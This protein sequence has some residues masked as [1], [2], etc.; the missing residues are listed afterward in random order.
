MTKIYT[1]L[2]MVTL[3]IGTSAWVSAQTTKFQRIIGGSDDDRSYSM[4]QTRDGGYI[5]TGY[6]KSFG[7]GGK[8]IYLTKTNGLGKVIWSKTYGTSADEAGWKVKQTYDS[9]YLVVGTSTAR[10]GDGVLFK[11]DGNGTMVWGKIFDSDSTDEIYNVLESRVNNAIYITG[12]TKTDSFGR[13]AFLSKYSSAGNIIWHR[14][15]GGPANEEGFSLVEEINGNI[16][17]VGLVVDDSVTVGGNS[18]SPGDEDFFIARF[19]PNG[20]KKWMK[21][22]GTSSKDQVWDI[23][24]LK[25]EYIM[26]GWTVQGSGNSEIMVATIDTNGTA[27]NANAYTYNGGGSSKAFTLVI[28]PDETISLTGQVATPSNKNDGFYLNITKTGFINN[29][30]FIGGNGDD[31]HWPSEVTRTAD[32]GFT[33]F[34]T[35]NSFK[36]SSHDL[37]MIRMDSKGV[38]DCNQSSPSATS[39]GFNLQSGNFGKV[40]LGAIF[41]TLSLT[42]KTITTTKDSVLCCKLQ[43]QVAA[44]SLRICKGDAIRIGKT[45]ISG[46]VYKWTQLAGGSFTSTESSPQVSPTGSATYR[47]VVSS[48]DGKCLKDSA[49]ITVSVRVELKNKNIVRDTFF[50]SGD[51]I[52]IKAANGLISYNWK[53]KKNTFTGQTIQLTKPDTLIITV[54]DTTTCKYMDTI[55]VE[56]KKLPI[57]SLGN[58]TTICDNTKI[59]LRGP[60]NMKSYLWNSGK[61]TTQNYLTSEE[62]THTLSVVDNFGCKHTDSKQLFNNPAS[63]FS[64]GPDTAMCKG[65]PYT[66]L[67]PGFLRDY[68]WDGVPTFNANKTITTPGTYIL[69]ASNTYGCKHTDTIVV[70]QRPDPTFSLGADGGVCATGGRTLI[71]PMNVT[72]YQWDDGSNSSTYK[73]FFAG[74]YWLKVT[75]ANG[76]VFTDSIKLT[77]VPNPVPKLGNDTTIFIGDSIYLDPGNFSTYNWSTG[78]TTRTIKVKTANLYRVEVSD[79]NGCKGESTKKVSTKQGSIHSSKIDGLKVY[80]NPAHSVLNFEWLFKNSGGSLAIYSLEGKMMF[81]LPTEPGLAKYTIDVSQWARGIYF[82]KVITESN[83]QSMKIILD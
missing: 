34:T 40:R 54:A 19:T 15:F 51:T 23:K 48:D 47:L 11:T 7:S 53:S 49:E 63:T 18:G 31:G 27:V 79:I 36:P 62:T 12:F 68:V 43:A 39:F 64:L 69:Q 30:N 29:F 55:K 59:L 6:T 78:A 42:T 52:R 83:Y 72:S 26:A 50:C 75:G 80:P 38:S 73:V 14:K 22:Y 32:G 5:L 2:L 56:M 1:R 9:G 58:D 67:G 65:I 70:K 37:Y 41:N 10:K 44:K 45:A 21:N 76:C 17:V 66:I 4:A 3:F 8:D 35:S 25:G 81:S 74:T 77:I 71:G 82:L 57:F 13:D 33:I 61:A 16:A 20:D 24:Y 46:Y 60:A 28:N